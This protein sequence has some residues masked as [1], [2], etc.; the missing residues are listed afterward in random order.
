MIA[1]F[2]EQSRA[3]PAFSAKAPQV[4]VDRVD[5]LSTCAFLGAASR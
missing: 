2:P 5:V 3:K 1:L 4:K